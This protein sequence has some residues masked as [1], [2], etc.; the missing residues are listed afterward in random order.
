MS[1]RSAGK[2][3]QTQE[4]NCD[5]KTGRLAIEYNFELTGA[6]IDIRMSTLST[7]SPNNLVKKYQYQKSF[8]RRGA[9]I[10]ISTTVP[11][12]NYYE[13]GALPPCILLVLAELIRVATWDITCAGGGVP[14]LVDLT[15]ELKEYT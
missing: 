15:G 6:N 2:T 12:H 9:T 4:T 1:S 13:M 11:R 3:E 7:L 14:A 8:A 5:Y 10:R